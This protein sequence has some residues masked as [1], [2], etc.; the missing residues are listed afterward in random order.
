MRQRGPAI[1]EG[2][3]DQKA[4]S[5]NFRTQGLNELSG[6]TRRTAGRQEVVVDED[7]VPGLNR[8]LDHFDRGV[9]IFQ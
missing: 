5:G 3:V 1:Q 8:A 7:F 6:S 4:E 2:Q 9:A